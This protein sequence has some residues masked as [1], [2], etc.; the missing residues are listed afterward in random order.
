[1]K[2][3]KEWKGE[4]EHQEAFEELKEKIT[5]QLVL[6]LPKKE[7]KFRVETDA[8]GHAIGGVLSQEQEGKWKPIAFLSRTMQ[9][10]EWNYKIYDKKLLAIVKALAKWRQYLLDAAETFEIWMDHE[11]LKYFWEP[12]KLNGRQARW[13]LKLQDYDFILQHIPGKTN[14]KADILSRKDQV[15]TKEDNKDV[16]LLKDEIWTRKITSKIKVFNERKR[17][18]E[19]DI[20]KK[21]RKN[22]TREKKVVQAL[23]REDGLTWEEDKVVYMEGRIYVPN[24][25]DLKEEILREHHDPADVGHPGQQRM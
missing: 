2:G 1:M 23:K 13:Y 15:D 9:P 17:I 6:A 18:D 4:K 12:H 24:N 11:N 8:S 19:S 21:I 20:I 14:T 25:K 3:K 10:A 16:Q 5:S 22:N 7:G